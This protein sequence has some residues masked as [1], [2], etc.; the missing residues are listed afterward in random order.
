MTTAI[1]PI[2]PPAESRA[3]PRRQLRAANL[4]FAVVHVLPLL[5]FVTGVTGRAIGLFVVL[6]VV[7]AFC[8]TAGYH[9]YFAHRTYQLG[10]LPQF[11]LAFGGAA[12]AQ[13]G[14]LWWAAHHR[15]HH[16]F[17]DEPG[18]PHSPNDGVWWSHVGWI[19]APEHGRTRTELI[20]DFARFPELRFLDRH[21][22]IA[23]WT[24][25]FLS[26][27]V[28]GWSG[29]VVGFFASTVLLWHATFS[30]NSVA[31]LLGWRRYETTDTSR[32][33][34]VVAFLTLG[35]GWHNNHHHLPTVARQGFRW[36]ELDVAYLVLRGLAAVGIVR[37]MREPTP[38]ALAA[39]RR[40]PAATG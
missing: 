13:K 2:S 19:L 32:N 12:A 33:N 38:K 21:D 27:Y 30:V 15:A 22:W 7:R 11:L 17:T 9:R 34:P 39:R 4:P 16:R 6:Y 1:S 26:W 20:E 37:D 36:W 25:G 29:L 5:A 14:P 40:V 10:R 23:P 8:I 35:E 24:L 18:D 3:R 28:A 31:H